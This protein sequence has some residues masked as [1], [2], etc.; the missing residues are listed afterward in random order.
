[1]LV[2]MVVVVL[3]PLL[4]YVLR[5]RWGCCWWSLNPILFGRCDSTAS[6]RNE[7]SLF[8]RYFVQSI[9]WGGRR[10]CLWYSLMDGLMQMGCKD[11][12]S[13]LSGSF[14][15]WDVHLWWWVLSLA[16]RLKWIIVVLWYTNGGYQSCL[17]RRRRQS[18]LLLYCPTR[19]QRCHL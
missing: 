19:F 2:A 16:S 6:Q 14:S 15:R 1:M 13:Y 9:Y 11:T 7:Y 17:H 5:L 4:R 3:Q 12:G 8:C 18:I 10:W